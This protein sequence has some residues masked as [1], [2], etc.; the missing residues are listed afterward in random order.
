MRTILH[1]LWTEPAYF[2]KSIAVFVAGLAAFL[3]TLPLEEW[4][5]VGY[6]LGKVALPLAVLVAARGGNNRSG[7]TQDEA[8]KLRAL[9][10]T[11]AQ[12]DAGAPKV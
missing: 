4:G 5:T 1:N 8:A 11:Q 10:P 7:L 6:W 3:P 2:Q 12:L 9:I